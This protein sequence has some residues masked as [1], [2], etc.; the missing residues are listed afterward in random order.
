M[1]HEGFTENLWE[2]SLYVGVFITCG[3]FHYVICQEDLFFKW[4]SAFKFAY[5]DLYFHFMQ[6]LYH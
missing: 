1:F 6:E 3:C 2:F 4:L 5:I